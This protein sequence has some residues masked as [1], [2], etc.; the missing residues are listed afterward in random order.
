MTNEF[1]KLLKPQNVFLTKKRLGPNEDGGYVMPNFVFENCSAL[2]TYGVGSEVRFEVEFAKTYQKPAYLFDHIIYGPVPGYEEHQQKELIRM[3]QYFKENGCVFNPTGLGFGEKCHDFY[4]DYKDLNID[5]HV[6]LKIDIEGAE[7][8][9]FSQTD[10]S[11]F[12][13]SVM[14][15]SL[16]V[17][18]IHAP[19]YHDKLVE[20]L[21]KIEKYFV[22]CHIHGNNWGETWEYE[23]YTIPVTLELSF[24]NKKFVNK[25]VPDEQDYPIEGLDIPNRPPDKEGN[26]YPDYKLTFLKMIST[27][28]QDTVQESIQEPIQETVQKPVNTSLQETSNDV[29]EKVFVN[30]YNND[31]FFSGGESRSGSGSSVEMTEPI[32]PKI[33]ELI[34]NKNIKSVVDAACGDFNWMKEIVFR[35]E[36]YTGLDVVPECIK[37]DNERYGNSRIKFNVHNI[38]TD[39]IPDGDLLI[40]RDVIGH[41]PLKDGEQ[42]LSNILRSNCK[43]LLATTWYH[44]TDKSFNKRHL[45][46][47]IPIGRWYAL[48]LMSD[49]FNLPDPE[50]IIEEINKVEDY[51]QGVRKILGLWNIEELKSGRNIEKTVSK[52]ESISDSKINLEAEP[53]LDYYIEKYGTDKLKSGYSRYYEQLFKT[54]RNKKMNILE[55]GIGTLQAGIPSTFIGNSG[56]YP[57]Y[58]PGGSLRAW[59]DYFK[60]SQIYGIDIADDCLFEEE[61]IKTFI[62]SSLDR[63]KCDEN[64]LNMSFDV[65]IDDG[66]HTAAGQIATMQNLFDRVKINGYY[67]I[68]DCGGSGDGSYVST[69][70]NEEFKKI[71]DDHE[72]VSL[73]NIIFIRKNNSGKGNIGN[74]EYFLKPELRPHLK[75]FDIPELNIKNKEL[76][77]VTG[78][79]DIGR[80]GRD[81]THYIDHFKNFLDIPV[82]MFIYIPQK[83]EYLVWEKRSKKNTYVKIMELNDIKTLYN[84]FW[85]KTQ[86]IRTDPRW[87]NSTGEHGWLSGSPQATLEWY[88]PIVQSKMFFLNDATIW[89]PFGSEF[90]IW[91]DAGI[92]NTVYDKFF[93]ENRALDKIIP[94]LSN[95][96]LFLSYPYETVTEIHGF[97]YT[98]MNMYARDTVKYVCRGGLFG[99]KKEAIN[100]ASSTYYSLLDKTLSEGYMGTEESI[101]A[102]M[103]YREPHLY[104]RYALDGNG[105]ISKFIEALINDN[106]VLEPVPKNVIRTSISNYELSKIKTNVYML[107]F[108]FPEQVQHTIDTMEKVPE[109]LKNPHLVLIDNSINKEAIAGNKIIAEKYNMEYIH[110]EENT[111]ICGG[112]QKAAEHFHESDADFMLFF[113]DD[114]TINPPDLDG[115]FC[116]NGFRKYIPNLYN[117]IHKIMLKEQFDFLKLSFTEVY[118]D[119]EKSLPWYNVPQDIR[120]R[121]WP[122]YDKLP[123][124]G[125]DPNSP[126][127]NYSHINTYEGIS[128]LIGDIN[129]CNWPMIVSKEGNK[130]MFIDTKWARPYEQTWSSH[131][132]QLTKEGK[133]KSGLLLSSPIWHDRIKYYEPEERREN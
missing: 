18:W 37:T 128:Y 34:K 87:F 109:W 55:V 44:L 36:T 115:Q 75:I 127:A 31:G 16:E 46:E 52:I 2:F 91:L 28:V 85:N 15:I 122:D 86:K 94:Y 5:G 101:F 53:N 32:R 126:L 112:R 116:R 95:G 70:F 117:I 41:Y 131:I 113:E 9:Y 45:N 79:W 14:A 39:P 12:E 74:L 96:F 83:Y 26:V 72:Y 43:Y 93:T 88:N 6:F 29:I 64:L 120:T 10:L 129:Y 63:E 25:C 59:R 1:I 66:L 62:F 60:N 98:A 108:N 106:V 105:L 125:L 13:N 54:F 21:K 81:F 92:T 65:I 69:D 19:Q 57:H 124:T 133:I 110:M 118:F 97:T 82:N 27:D 24:I 30:I 102:I 71:T 51:D 132:Y 90:F 78:L 35:F 8:D 111:G 11:N 49:P 40:L 3:T 33:V 7:Y 17:H 42:I 121:D 4:Q 123:L 104:R 77:V 119:N 50:S 22:L 56:L 100:Q 38:L 67:I 58:K 48:N 73:G 20:I 68:E 80:M 103:S 99:G 84:P 47:D 114:M 61:R 76:T 107:T 23:G 130:K 89:N